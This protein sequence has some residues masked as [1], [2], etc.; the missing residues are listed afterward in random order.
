MLQPG[1]T[2]LGKFRV[3]SMIG[4]GGMASVWRGTH[5]ATGRRIA[6]KILDDRFLGNARVV[7]RFGREARAASAVQHESIVDV[8][9]LDRTE[10]G[11]PF[12]VMEFLDGE[13]LA[14][15]IERKGR[16]SEA[17][18]VAIADPLLDA[19]HAAHQAGVVHR[20]L[21][22]DNVMLVPAGR[23]G[24]KLKVL[25]FGISSKADEI[26]SLTTTGSLLGTPHYM[27]P[28]Q[29][30]GRTDIDRR[31]DLYAMGVLLYEC[32][33]GDVPFDAE[34]YNALIHEILNTPPEPPRA[35]GATIS[36][37]VEAV[38]LEAL[39]KDR[40]AR[41]ASAEILRERLIEV[42]VRPS[43]ANTSGPFVVM[44]AEA[45]VQDVAIEAKSRLPTQSGAPLAEGGLDALLLRE[46]TLGDLHLPP[47]T[48]RPSS[49]R[50][51]ELS[52]LPSTT[53][54]GPSEKLQLDVAARRPP[55]RSA[56]GPALRAPVDGD[57]AFLSRRRTRAVVLAC[58]AIVVLI[59]VV[60]VA[61]RPEWILELVHSARAAEP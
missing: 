9:D 28:E 57:A 45:P 11:E 48:R 55:R 34:N 59:V 58:C 26:S 39:A 30:R 53:P 32:A 17:E 10:A 36:A 3:E 47:P 52:A 15:R 13:T 23:R 4:Q 51:S 56:S 44:Q 54:P 5:L 6:V 43:S 25:D 33:V 8:L 7:E 16:L 19:L 46:P 22:P 38:I 37:A 61:M 40:T 21:K 60:R 20:D 12:L 2:L 18:L 1:Q 14:E 27:S 35:R 50:G 42:A 24:E 31:A 41:P 49:G 29:A